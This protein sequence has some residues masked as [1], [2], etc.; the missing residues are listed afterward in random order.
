MMNFISSLNPDIIYCFGWSKLLSPEI[1]CLAPKG[2]IGFHPTKL[3]HNRGR[4]PIIWSLVLGL[5]ETASTFSKWMMV[6]I[7]EKFCRKK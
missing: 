6:L 7:V 3:P 1:F 2:V 4:H 5:E